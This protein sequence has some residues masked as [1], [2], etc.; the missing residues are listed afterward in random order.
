[1]TLI[2]PACRRFDGERMLAASLVESGGGLTCR[3]CGRFHPVL[4][5]VPIVLKDLDG[6]VD[7]ELASVVARSDVPAWARVGTLDRDDRVL[8]AAMDSPLRDRVRALVDELPGA[9]LD[10]GCGVGLH[11]RRDVIGMDLSFPVARA[12]VG[13]GFVA[14][15]ADPP[16]TPFSFDAVLLLNLL[17]SCRSPR[18][19]LAQADAL[20]KPGGLLLISCP[21]AWSDGTPPSRRFTAQQLTRSLQGGRD[22]G[23]SLNYRLQDTEE[24]TWRLRAGPNSVHEHVCTLWQAEKLVPEGALR[25]QPGGHGRESSAQGASAGSQKTSATQPREPA[26]GLLQAH[27]EVQASPEVQVLQGGL[28]RPLR[29]MLRNRNERQR[30]P[31]QLPGTERGFLPLL[32]PSEKAHA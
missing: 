8:N 7:Q 10:M 3:G 13:Q 28:Q 29:G 11:A 31:W 25:H 9:V 1:M 6:W 19:V 24:W 22:L 4:D 20:L 14:D 32:S 17:D 5:G 12:F 23:L 2:C 30:N 16:F 15:A 26:H 18:Q 27:A 21:F